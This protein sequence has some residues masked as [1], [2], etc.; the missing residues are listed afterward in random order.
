MYKHMGDVVIKILQG[1]AVTLTMLGGL[2]ILRLQISYSVY[3]PKIMKI[4]WQ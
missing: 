4:G 3:V 1:S 2:T